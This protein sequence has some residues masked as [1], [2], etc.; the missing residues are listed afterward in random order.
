MINWAKLTGFQWDNGNSRKSVEKHGVGQ[1]EVEQIFF[2]EPLLLLVDE[3]HSSSEARYH[4]LGVTDDGRL[5]HC[6][7]TLRNTSTLIRVISV[8][9]MHRKER[10][11]YEQN[12][13]NTSV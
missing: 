10:A 2:N 5:L 11:I 8:R 4:G 13:K 12:Q 9:D 7:F 3:K 1:S 6:T